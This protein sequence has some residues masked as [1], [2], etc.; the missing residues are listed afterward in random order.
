VGKPQGLVALSDN[1][2]RVIALSKKLRA[3]PGN[4]ERSRK[5][6]FRNPAGVSFKMSNLQSV[7]TGRGLANASATDRVVWTYFGARRSRLKEVANQILN[8]VGEVSLDTSEVENDEFPEGAVLTKVH[9]RIERNHRLRTNLIRDRRKNNLLRCDA[10]LMV[11]PTSEKRFD[12]AIFDAHHLVPLSAIGT[13]RTKIS[14]MALLCA[15]CHRII[16]RLSSST[17]KWAS[18]NDVQEALGH[19]QSDGEDR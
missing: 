3:F 6:S 1:D 5:E 19:V 14:D 9:R 8:F 2:H 18:V 15:N 12:D 16:H 4:E 17:G 11:N 7:A 13:T 10:C